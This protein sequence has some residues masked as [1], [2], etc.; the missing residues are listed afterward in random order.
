MW[1]FQGTNRFLRGG[2]DPQIIVSLWYN[3]DI[4]IAICKGELYEKDKAHSVKKQLS[5]YMGLI[6]EIMH[7]FL[8]KA[9]IIIIIF[10]QNGINGRLI[11]AQ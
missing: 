7:R 9:E 8:E 10:S 11:Q 5:D 2:F 3:R 4:R 6:F 1:N